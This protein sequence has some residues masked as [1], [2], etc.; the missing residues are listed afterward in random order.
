MV[1]VMS[2]DLRKHP[3]DDV[4]KR[5]QGSLQTSFD[6]ET[7]VRKRRSVGFRTD[8]DTWVRI[9]IRNLDR[10]DG[11]SWGVEAA[12]VLKDVAMPE[13]HQGT[14]WLDHKRVVMWRAD[15][16]EYIADLPVKPGGTLAVDPALSETW[17]TAFNTSLSALAGHMTARTATPHLQPITQ[18]RLTRTI[19]S[20]FPEVNTIITE[21]TA[22]H[23]DLAW[24]N[25]TGPNC[26]LLD[27]EDWGM[28][29]RGWDASTL[30]S[31]SLAVPTLAD[32][33][34]QERRM[35]METRTGKLVQLYHC[36]EL[37]SAPVGYAD[38]L[39]EPAATHST[40]LLT[41]LRA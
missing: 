19:H 30:W 16:T 37:L 34:L 24:A 11:Q 10:S 13:W 4:V 39:L 6:L 1:R 40:Q 8:R 9:E 7:E 36:A 32:R 15:E 18:A 41:D 26:Y 17:W 31:A 25:L 22:A 27:W 2:F 20:V 21:W 12:S 33:V 35:D 23:A 29:P 28:A 38:A 5:V 14:S 3:T